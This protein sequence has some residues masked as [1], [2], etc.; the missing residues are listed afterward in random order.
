MTVSA[1]ARPTRATVLRIARQSVV[2]A[3]EMV[4]LHLDGG[5]TVRGSALHPLADGR[6]LGG[7]K[8]GDRVDG[9]VVTA[10]S[11]TPFAG[12]ATWDLLP[13]GETGIYFIGG[14][15]LGS[16]LRPARVCRGKS[17]QNQLD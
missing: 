5:R 1:D 15:P 17:C 12:D 14:V 9:T 2:T 11:R 7:L 16:T 13:S 10:V 3:H 6:A 4:V 8:V